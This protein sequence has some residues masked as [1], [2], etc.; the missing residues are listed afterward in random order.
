[1]VCNE[2]CFVSMDRVQ[3]HSNNQPGQK[4]KVHD[5]NERSHR[6]R[7]D[8]LKAFSCQRRVST[9]AIQETF[10]GFHVDVTLRL[11]GNF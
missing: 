3:D 8:Y 2:G 7:G 10:H 4:R 6:D 1:M 9:L 11:P 5:A